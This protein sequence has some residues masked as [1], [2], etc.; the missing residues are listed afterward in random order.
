MTCTQ[1]CKHCIYGE[2]KTKI[3]CKDN[4]V[5]C[6]SMGNADTCRNCSYKY[7]IVVGYKCTKL[8]IVS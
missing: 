5:T 2:P 4:D 3:L 8:N 6:N 1:D 7:E